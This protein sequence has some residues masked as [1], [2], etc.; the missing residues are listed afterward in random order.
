M[1]ECAQAILDYLIENGI[2]E[3]REGKT[4]TK[5]VATNGNKVVDAAPKS[6]SIEVSNK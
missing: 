1:N 2:C 5:E 3:A 6:T 4:T